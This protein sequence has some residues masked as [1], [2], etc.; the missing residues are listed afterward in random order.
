MRPRWAL[1]LNPPHGPISAEVLS[2]SLFT[3]EGTKAQKELMTQL[4]SGSIW[5][6]CKADSKA[7]PIN[8]YVIPPQQ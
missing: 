7:Y 1:A 2:S 6:S 5:D 4:K 8:H 3:D